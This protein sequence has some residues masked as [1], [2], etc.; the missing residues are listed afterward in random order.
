MTPTELEQVDGAVATLV[1]AAFAPLAVLSEEVALNL[2]SA[3]RCRDEVKRR[4]ALLN[5]TLE[6]TP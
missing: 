1:H 3:A 4:L 6:A 2:R 5:Q